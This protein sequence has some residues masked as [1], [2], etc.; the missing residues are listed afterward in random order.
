VHG[1]LD[2]WPLLATL[3][4]YNSILAV[5]A[6][7]YVIGMGLALLGFALWLGLG[8]RRLGLA[9]LV[10]TAVSMALYFA[11]LVAFAAYGLMVM[12]SALSQAHAARSAGTR[13]SLTIVLLAASQLVPAGILAITV[14]TRFPGSL[15]SYGGVRDKLVAL[16]SPTL[17]YAEKI[18]FITFAA[19]ALGLIWL[20]ASRRLS[21][22]REL[23]L[24]IVGLAIVAAAMPSYLNGIY[25]VDRRLPPLVVFLL[26]AATRLEPGSPT[27]ARCVAA[28]LIVLLSWRLWGVAERWQTIDAQYGEYRRATVGLPA[29]ARLL[30]VE[31]RVDAGR[32]AD[33]L[34]YAH[35]HLAALSVIERAAFVPSLFTYTGPVFAGKRTARID[36]PATQPLSPEDLRRGAGVSEGTK[37]G[38]PIGRLGQPYYWANW[39]QNYDYVVWLH[40]GAGARGLPEA[41]LAPQASGSFF[42]IFRVVPD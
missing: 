7:N 42:D 36:A 31:N 2:Y 26:I 28:G 14:T 33:L 13:R 24:S 39:P 9:V 1:H 34:R 37:L 27:V 15:T 35:V 18:D 41:H 29:G 19:V 5:G 16:A 8:R 3:F 17:F 21:F 22:A 30:M 38:G 10:G 20:L 11:H 12:L 4:L 32:P 25:A 40:Y 23:R 6:L